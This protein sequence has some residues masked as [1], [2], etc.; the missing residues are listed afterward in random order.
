MF[1]YPIKLNKIFDKL[2][3]NDA[4][5][6]IVGGYVRDAIL[7][8]NSQDIDVEVYNIASFELLEE[9]LKE[10]GATNSVGKSFGV[11]KLD[12][13]EF[14]LDFTLPRTDSK[15]SNG[16]TGFD[17]KIDS[18]LDYKSA[19]SRRDFSINTIGYD[20]ASK[21]LLDPFNGIKDLKAKVLRVVDATK[22]G[23]DPLRVL[24]AMQFCARFEL[25]A[26]KQLISICQ[27]MCKDKLLDELAYERIFEEFKKL[28]K[29]S[30]PSIGLQFLKQINALEFFYELDLEE[31][32]WDFTLEVL[33]RCEKNITVQFASLCYKMTQEN[34]DSFIRKLTNQKQLLRE[35]KQ[36]HH[37]VDYL[38]LKSKVLKYSII[39]DANLKNINFFLVALGYKERDLN[40]LKPTV[41]GKELLKVEF[42]PSKEF[43]KLLQ[44]VYEIQLLH[45]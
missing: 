10:F 16:H 40:Y 37:I 19:S 12:F 17:I 21:T 15:V 28:L 1:N 26:D 32:E 45:L 38:T 3:H 31:K 11:C 9:M 34:K 35:I 6:I 43:S 23:E 42:K 44:L 14:K 27:N 41:H 33:D 18:S 4:K 2:I 13:D 24:R 29:S 30:K 25:V 7:Q 39:K 22:F 36:Y 8:I 20:I 5:P